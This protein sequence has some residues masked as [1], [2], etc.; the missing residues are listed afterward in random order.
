MLAKLLKYDFK[1]MFKN[2]LPLWG[3]LL[4][5]SGINRLFTGAGLDA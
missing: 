1:A 2:F 5:V 4:V 3:V